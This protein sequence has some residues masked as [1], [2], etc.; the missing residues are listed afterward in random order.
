MGCCFWQAQRTLRDRVGH[1]TKWLC[2]CWL[3]R[4]GQGSYAAS[5]VRQDTTGAGP[6]PE[7]QPKTAQRFSVGSASPGEHKSRRDGRAKPGFSAVPS[8]L[9]SFRRLYPTL[10]RWAIIGRPFG[11]RTQETPRWRATGQLFCP[12]PH[13]VRAGPR[14]TI[15]SGRFAEA[16]TIWRA[17][18][19]EAESDRQV[20]FSVKSTLVE[21][22]AAHRHRS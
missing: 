22:L 3:G 14:F 12:A 4:A 15:V 5:C 20:P 9:V 6:V 17:G 18:R 16:G 19:P 13:R 21:S 8:G 1:R 7:G 11:T 2:C 10:K